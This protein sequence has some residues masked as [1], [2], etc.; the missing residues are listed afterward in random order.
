MKSCALDVFSAKLKQHRDDISNWS[1]LRSGFRIK[2]RLFETCF[3][4]SPP[5]PRL[6]HIRDIKER[7]VAELNACPA[8]RPLCSKEPE[9]L[10][11]T[12]SLYCVHA[13]ISLLRRTS[14]DG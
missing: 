13:V 11:R 1:E 12:L 9:P 3:R 2:F 7:C 6:Y 14:Y 4:S 5:T 10:I 8:S